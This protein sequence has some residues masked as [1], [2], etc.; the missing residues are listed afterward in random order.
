MS[1]QAEVV[2]KRIE[3]EVAKLNGRRHEISFD[4]DTGEPGLE[5]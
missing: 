1:Q 4:L 3:D 5:T 2:L